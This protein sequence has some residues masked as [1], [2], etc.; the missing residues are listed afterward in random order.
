MASD[1]QCWAPDLSTGVVADGTA[2]KSTSGAC[3]EEFAMFKFM[4][5]KLYHKSTGYCVGV[6]K[7]VRFYISQR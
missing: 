1:G 7:D 5:N 4:D 3:N 6:G 2:L